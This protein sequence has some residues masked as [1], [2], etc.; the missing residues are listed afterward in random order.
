MALQREQGSGQSWRRGSSPRPFARNVP[1][2]N[3]RGARESKNV[4]GVDNAI[5]PH[6]I[7]AS[8]LGPELSFKNGAKMKAIKTIIAIVGNAGLLYAGYVLI[9]S[10]PDVR[11][12]IKISTM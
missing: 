5:M 3:Y 2:F 7:L 6:R 9:L 10:M 1:A 4:T 12:Y 8:I 11:R